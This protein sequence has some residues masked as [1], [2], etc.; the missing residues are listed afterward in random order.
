M[1]QINPN[2]HYNIRKYQPN[3]KAENFAMP[4]NQM[5]TQEI[6]DIQLP[7]IYQ[8]PEGQ[9]EE[10]N[11]KETVKKFDMFD[12][13]SPWLEYPVLT[14][15]TAA[16][17][18]W[19]IDQFTKAWSGEYKSSLLGKATKLGDN[20]TNA[21]V[22]K[23]KPVKKVLDGVGKVWTKI[24]GKIGENSMVKAMRET[25]CLPEW[26]FGKIETISQNR[27][28]IQDDFIKIV[29]N[30]ALDSDGAIALKNIGLNKEE[31]NY[32][33]KMFK[34]DRLAKLPEEKAVN[35][36]LMKRLG[37]SEAEITRFADMGKGGLSSIKEELRKVLGLTTDDIKNIRV[38]EADKYVSKVFD[39]A[40]KGKG[41]IWVGDGEMPI[42]GK[43]QPLKRKI[44]FDSVYNRMHSIADGA[45]TKLGRGFSQAIQ[46]VYRG[47]TFGGGK[48]GMLIFIVPN[49]VR[50]AVNT[51]KAEPEEK[52]STAIQ[53]GIGAISWVI[54]M[55]LATK[56]LYS[57]GGIKYAGMGKDKVN[58]YRE[59]IKNFNATAVNLDKATYNTR[60][61]ALKEQL[62]NLRK[63][64]G[65]NLITKMSRK[66]ASI[67]TSDL[68]MIQP[69]KDSFFGKL[70]K[71]GKN[72]GNIPVRFIAFM[73]ISALLDGIIHKTISGIFGRAHSEED[74]RAHK[75]EKARQKKFTRE[76]LEN[77]LLEAQQKKVLGIDQPEQQQFEI[78]EYAHREDA[79]SNDEIIENTV[80]PSQIPGQENKIKLPE[81]TNINEPAELNS[82]KTTAPVQT[83]E[84][85]N[86]QVNEP[87]LNT[88]AMTYNPQTQQ[89]ETQQPIAFPNNSQIEQ[90]AEEILAKD[91][92]T[93]IP[94]S[95]PAAEVLQEKGSNLDKY[96]YIP[97]QDNVLNKTTATNTIEKYIPSQMGAKFT[98]TFDNSG[99]QDALNRANKAEKQA[100]EIL[101]GKF[102]GI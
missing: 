39:A 37:K 95:K 41:K 94:S 98:K 33:L 77:R 66:I 53:G 96:T 91:D 62:K 99:L 72:A 13:V 89:L 21:K 34:V 32:L 20:I 18:L 90:P 45:K 22:F 43:F 79:S 28:I 65:Q 68:G 44:G 30:L 35:A 31:Q 38:D 10:K 101:N 8:I 46:K 73:T 52:V 6:S 70:G 48:G 49:L 54:T 9:Y 58:Q 100:I 60:K 56:A 3:F 97:S 51:A 55:P 86:Q 83:Q 4:Y 84:M 29:D 50:A 40:K 88:E 61:K 63:V 85:Q 2:L 1:S 57:L 23:V 59:L 76:D 47:F 11:F 82:S 87:A 80:V 5:P 92:Y 78:P 71:F 69:H 19:G 12:A 25:P 26:S 16:T 27:R 64:D 74:V 67:F 14:A 17:T 7:E 36:I 93:Y 102:P 75:E 81:N 15:G 42:L 24:T